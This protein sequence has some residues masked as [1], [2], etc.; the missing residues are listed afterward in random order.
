MKTNLLALF[1]I[2]A[3]AGCSNPNINR[4]VISLNGIW[5][6]TR[7]DTL[8]V[9]PHQ[10][11]GKVQVPGLVDMADTCLESFDKIFTDTTHI[12]KN[13]SIY[14]NNSK[15]WYRRAFSV[16]ANYGDI[17]Y[18]K[19]N[20]AQY[21]TWVY[22]NGNLAG[23]NLYS[24]TPALINI[25][26]FLNKGG[27]E[28]ELVI[29]VGSRNNLPDTVINGC[30]YEKV[31]FI[32]GIYDD[33]KLILSGIPNIINVQT[34]PEI[35]ENKLRVVAEIG[36]KQGTPFRLSYKIQESVSRKTVAEGKIGQLIMRDKDKVTSD[37]RIDI[38]GARL[39]TPEDPF[40]YELELSTGADNYHTL[41]G[42][43][44]F[45]V[46]EDSAVVLLNGKPYYMRGT[47]VCI[48]RFF[49]DS[50]K[51]ELPWD[52]KWVIKLHQAFKAM[53]GNSIRYCI[54]FP[55]ELW[56]EV[57]DSLGFLIQDEYPIWGFDQE[58]RPSQITSRQL[59][60]EYETW[61]RE[62]WNHPCVVIWDAQNET[63]SDTIALSI[64]KVRMLDLSGRPWDNG[65]S[66]PAS[67]SDVS[68][69]HP[70]LFYPLYDKLRKNVKQGITERGSLFKD[71]LAAPRVPAGGPPD[72]KEKSF[73][74]PVIINE[75]AWAWINRD[76]SPTTLTDDIYTRLFP[77]A[78]TPEKRLEL[79]A[80][81]LGMKT[82]FWRSQRNAAGVL[83]FCGLGYSRPFPPRGQ[84]SDHLKDVRNV[85]L[86]PFFVKYVRP[87]FNPVGIMVGFWDEKIQPGTEI[88]F[89]VSI[90]NDTYETWKGRIQISLDYN[91]KS[92][93]E[94]FIECEI[95]PLGKK[96]HNITMQLPS[97]AGKYTL[98][99][100]I[101]YNNEVVRSIR[102]FSIK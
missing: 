28:N 34:V 88:S 73:P 80:R 63:R 3:I 2:V 30:D 21:H 61:M 14:Y 86:D 100:E 43:R 25:K 68:E 60:K 29:A 66:A 71:L 70:Y 65:W 4:T 46:S 6:I 67:V 24:F 45:K 15:Y 87:A 49:E 55:P 52:R 93:N 11:T 81:I 75:Y 62:R 9:L 101:T 72:R 91:S 53:H 7:T 98:S 19:I 64:N 82:E 83:E 38:P 56:Y 59:A 33:V 36:V 41:F 26:Q 10:Y 16:P 92:I 42:M 94:Q 1:V 22:V 69:A 39:W 77:E 85:V 96:V 79:Y 50:A 12:V 57:A 99:G 17:A 47:N 48:N 51:A 97:V 54:G 5:D 32:P 27:K 95:K 102:E 58:N 84:T 18:L 89:P 76:G 31:F 78:D 35:N 90:I 44:S 23:E 37:F 74:N 20:K 8:T 13:K 40:L